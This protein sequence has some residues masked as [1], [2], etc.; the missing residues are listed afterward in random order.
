MASV[1]LRS[2]ART[3]TVD[4]VE[5]CL[6][7]FSKQTVNKA[8]RC[9]Q[10]QDWTV[11]VHVVDDEEIE[12]LNAEHRGKLSATDVLSF[13]AITDHLDPETFHLYHPPQ[14][15]CSLYGA[16][17]REL[18]GSDERDLGDLIV[19]VPYVQRWCEHEGVQLAD[20]LPQLYV[21]G[22]CHLIGYDHVQDDDFERM[23]AVEDRVLQCMRDGNIDA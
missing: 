15:S 16:A 6:K 2:T 13:P 22:L 19:A 8:L 20:R 7:E 14:P 17:D 11:T 23:Q 9:M 4:G 21:H 12:M 18:D 10:L 3:L 5:N 1:L